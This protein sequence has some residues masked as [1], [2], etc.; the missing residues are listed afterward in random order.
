MDLRA[1]GD[2]MYDIKTKVEPI[3]ISKQITGNGFDLVYG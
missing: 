3:S 1:I 2:G